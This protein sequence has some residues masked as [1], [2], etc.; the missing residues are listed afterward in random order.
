[1]PFVV[2]DAQNQNKTSKVAVRFASVPTWMAEKEK[3]LN[4]QK[5]A[6][7]WLKIAF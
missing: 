6:L 7:T 5:M 3:I 1:M 4:G 2:P